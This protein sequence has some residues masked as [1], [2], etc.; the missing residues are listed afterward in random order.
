MKILVDENI[1]KITTMALQKLEHDV[2][3][4]R[5]TPEEGSTD[6]QLWSIAQEE[7]RLL[8]STDRGFANR[9]FEAHSGIL[10]VILHQPNRQKIHDRVL[11]AVNH[12]AEDDWI[13]QL[14]IMRDTA[15]SVW[16]PSTFSQ[17]GKPDE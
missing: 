2:K 6:E 4:L 9:R 12:Y 5:G 14:F 13:G 17:E 7:S 16:R 10:L 3:D 15:Q 11:R 1:P 8:I